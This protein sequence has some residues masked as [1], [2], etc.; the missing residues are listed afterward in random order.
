MPR[1][2]SQCLRL[3]SHAA[4]VGSSKPE[5][6]VLLWGGRSWCSGTPSKLVLLC[7]LFPRP[8]EKAARHIFP[9]GHAGCKCLRICPSSLTWRLVGFE[10]LVPEGHGLH[11]RALVEVFVGLVG[12]VVA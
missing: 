5:L 1:P 6:P 11:R 3:L 10:S 7:R 8:V 4:C 2:S 9:G 12:G